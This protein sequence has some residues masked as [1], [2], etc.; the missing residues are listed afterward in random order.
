MCPTCGVSPRAHL[1]RDTPPFADR[2]YTDPVTGYPFPRCGDES[3]YTGLCTVRPQSRPWQRMCAEWAVQHHRDHHATSRP[4]AGNPID[5][6]LIAAAATLPRQ[7]RIVLDATSAEERGS[8]RCCSGD[9]CSR[10]VTKH[11]LA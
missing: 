8:Y 4:S 2:V 5:I 11:T 7:E 9:G 1:W 3:T 6:A 10:L